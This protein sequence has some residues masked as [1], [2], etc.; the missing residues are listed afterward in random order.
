MVADVL[1]MTLGHVWRTL[2]ATGTK[3]AVMGGIAL[4]SWKYVRATRDVD[5]LVGLE[6]KSVDGLVEQLRAVGV[7]PRRQPPVVNLGRLRLIQCLY[8]PPDKFLDVQIDLLLAECPYQLQ[9]LTRSVPEQLAGLGVLVSVLACEDLIL[10]KLL[11]GR[12]IDRVDC[13]SLIRLQRDNLDWA[14]LQNWSA[15]LSVGQELQEAWREAFPGERM[16]GPE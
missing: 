1:L 3:M 8:E 11:A 16:P 2:E 5:L 10:H 12:V 15:Y 9:A 13:V 6:G 4:A 14:Y 7:R